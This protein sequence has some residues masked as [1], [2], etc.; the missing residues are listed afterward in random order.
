MIDPKNFPRPLE[1]IP[2]RWYSRPELILQK[3]AW[4][5]FS[6]GPFG[7]IG[8]NLALM[9]LRTL[10]SKLVKEFDI[11]FAPGEDGTKL[12]TETT[13]HFTLGVAPLNLVFS[14][15]Q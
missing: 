10:V 4:Q 13:E 3:D 6:S 8:K 11:A 5:P 15:R 7:C 14:K 9:E 2:E 12:L 1:L